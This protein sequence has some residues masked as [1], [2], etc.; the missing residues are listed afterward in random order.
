MTTPSIKLTRAPAAP[1]LLELDATQAKA[2]AHRG[3]PLLIAGGPGTGKTSVLIEA[4]LSRIAAGQDPDSI[5]LIT[6]G[7][8][9]ASELRDSIALR[10]TV[11]MHEPLARTFHSLAYSILRWTQARIITNRFCYLALNKKIS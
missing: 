5:L 10:T 9:R 2:A 6:Y 11:T 3:S 4:A 8:E 7:R 1:A